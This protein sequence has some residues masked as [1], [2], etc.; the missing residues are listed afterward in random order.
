MATQTQSQRQAA[1]QKAAATRK[2]NAT[3]RSAAAT[4]SSARQTGRSASASAKGTTR[5]AGRT[6]KHAARTAGRGFDTA[7]TRLEALGRQAQ[8][9]LLI[10]VGAAATVGDKVKQT[11]RTYS[12]PGRVGRELNRLERRGAQTVNRQQR[13]LSRRRRELSHDVR[14]ARREFESRADGLRADAKETAEQVLRLR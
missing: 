5:G 1:A 3:K 4:K 6:G 2:R 11:T 8:R 13:T 14:G 10:Q 9:A 12:S 7:V